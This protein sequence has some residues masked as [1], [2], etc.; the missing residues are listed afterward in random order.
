MEQRLTLN[1]HRLI[2]QHLYSSNN[3]RGVVTH[4]KSNHMKKKNHSIKHTGPGGFDHLASDSDFYAKSPSE[5]PLYQDHPSAEMNRVRKTN[6]HQGV[7]GPRKA[8]LDP[9]EKMALIAILRAGIMIILLVIAFFMLYKGIKIYEEQVWMDNQTV[10]EESPVMRNVALIEDFNIADQAKDSFAHR[11]EMWKETERMVRSADDLLL[12]NN[13]D[14]AMARCH[15]ALKLDPAHTGALERLGLLYFKKG[16][17]AESVNTYI[18]LLSVNPSREVFQ[19]ALLK[20]LN[21]YGDSDATIYVAQWYQEQN[22]YNEDVQRY[23]ANAY[24]NQENYTEAAIAYERVLKGSPRNTE[25][26]EKQ[27][28]SYMRLEQ[29]EKALASLNKLVAINFRDPD[30]YKSI[31]IC[32]AQ[33]GRGLETVQTLGKAAHLFGQEAAMMW[34]QDPMLDPIRMDRTFQAFA[35]RVGGEEFRKYLEQM[36]QSMEG[37]APEDVTPQL[38]M[39]DTEA[40]DPE[41]LQPQQ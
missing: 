3:S 31:A 35:D 10:P 18:R 30:C 12:R 15:E 7:A 25:A 5:K 16:M 41:I 34:I 4:F 13:I 36:A 1:L 19:L 28:I 29:Y 20:S 17:Y 14:E 11:I 9:R 8:A 38:G 33:L 40:L 22:P 6:R 21:A 39:P 2:L 23:L 32:N 37:N 26:L 27:S 24:F